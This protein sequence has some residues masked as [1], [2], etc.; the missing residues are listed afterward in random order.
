M[1]G[2]PTLLGDYTQAGVNYWSFGPNNSG[3]LTFFWYDGSPRLAT[4]NTTIPLNT[5]THISVVINA[6]NIKSKLSII[7]KIFHCY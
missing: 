5:W 7:Q 6:T 4:G 2:T 3:L 1:A